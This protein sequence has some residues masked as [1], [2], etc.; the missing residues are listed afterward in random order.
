MST[1]DSTTETTR[2]SSQSRSKPQRALACVI[3]QQ[4]KVKCDRQFPCANCVKSRAQCVPATQVARRRRRFPER[5]LLER[6]R[7]YEGLLRH[8][9]IKFEP[10]H[11][12]AKGTPS[13]YIPP[14]MASNDG[15][16]TSE[17]LKGQVLH[18]DHGSDSSDDGRAQKSI[19]KKAWKQFI[20]NDD[21]L[22]FGS[23][24]T[25]LNISTLH[26]D[27]VQI[28]RMWQLY[29]DTINPLLKVTHTP[30]LQGRVIEAASNVSKINP[31]LE[32]L[33]FGIYCISLSSLTAKECKTMFGSTKE[34][35]LTKYQYACQ[36]ALWNCGFLRSSDRDSLTALYLYMVRH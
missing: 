30:S 1:T 15:P 22:V 33:M 25:A 36:Q 27:P 2:K 10:M 24:N 23:R 5:E 12:D 9:N 28:I 3:C 8:H 17:V 14:T 11:V 31:P 18:T 32:A 20:H 16:S 34:D 6:L 21:H 4:R 26:P 19:V 7:H 29:L 13:P 35:L